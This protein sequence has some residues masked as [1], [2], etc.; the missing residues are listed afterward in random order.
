[1]AFV[2]AKAIFFEVRSDFN[3]HA[4]LIATS[5]IQLQ[6]VEGVVDKV[7]H[8]TLVRVHARIKIFNKYTFVHKFMHKTLTH[9]IAFVVHLVLYICAHDSGCKRRHTFTD[10]CSGI[11]VV[12][13]CSDQ[14][15]VRLLVLRSL[16]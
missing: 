16:T 7:P 5:F 14:M 2:G 9:T 4:V 3:A 13:M 12:D 6:T 8:V 1:V 15:S 10:V 11:F